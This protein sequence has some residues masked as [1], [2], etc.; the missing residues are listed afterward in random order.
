MK[1]RTRWLMLVVALG[2]VTSLG[3]QDQVAKRDFDALKKHNEKLMAENVAMQ[4]EFEQFKT[5]QTEVAPVEVVTAPPAP[6]PVARPVDIN[7]LRQQLPSRAVV[8]MRGSQPVIRIDDK[9][10]CYGR[11]RAGVSAEGKRI[12]DRVAI[13]LNTE[14]AGAMVQVEGHTDSDPIKRLKPYHQNNRELGYARAQS[15][16]AY[17]VSRGVDPSRIQAS[18]FGEHRPVSTNK[19]K[20]RRVEI[21]VTPRGGLYGATTASSYMP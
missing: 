4:T 21:V 6:A 16:V 19:A 7:A 12:L 11:N 5:Q 9:L 17:L 15:V 8:Q 14:F 20:N 1:G 3:C 18:S 2:L 13:V 10:V